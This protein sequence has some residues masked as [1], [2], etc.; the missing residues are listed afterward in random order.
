MLVW[1]R[2][3]G[4]LWNVRC[5]CTLTVALMVWMVVPGA[6]VMTGRVCYGGCG[7]C[8]CCRITTGG[9]TAVGPGW[10]SGRSRWVRFRREFPL[11]GEALKV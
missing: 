3:G 7:C 1:W 4:H 10:T 2:N 9:G 11:S 8:C 6:T 5:R